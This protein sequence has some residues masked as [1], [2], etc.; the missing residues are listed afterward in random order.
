MAS[1]LPL[2]A[3]R[4]FAPLA[5]TLFAGAFNDN[6]YRTAMVL[7]VIYGIYADPAAEA[8]FSALAGGLFI[9]PFFL[10]SGLAGELADARDKAAI[11]RRV[12]DAE[13]VIMALGALGLVLGSVPLLL[14]MLFATGLQST[15]FGPIKYAL[16]PQH[17]APDEV[18][19]GTG[20]VEAATYVA[21]LVGIVA[22]GLVIVADAAGALEASW[23]AV[24]VVATAALGRVAA[25]YIPPAPPAAV[26]AR[27]DPNIARSTVRLVRAF[28]FRPRIGLAIWCISLFWAMGTMLAAIF[29]PLV[30]N[31]LGADPKV[32]TLFLASFSVGV[33]VG[34]VA[35]NRLLKGAVSARFAPWAVLGMAA[36]VLDL[37][38]SVGGFAGAETGAMDIATFVATP[39]GAW[40]LGDLFFIAALAGM[41]VV[42]L[43]AYL[44]THVGAD[45]T[46]RAVAANNVINSALMV[47]ASLALTAAYGAGVAVADGLL[48]VV[49]LALV[50]A[51]AG[52]RLH[53]LAE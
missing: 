26:A 33:A 24:G 2:L 23:G 31:A 43:Y 29:P 19:G 17:L 25:H 6:L 21:I 11:V 38:R 37:Y 12:K 52:W 13:I 1:P 49:A 8:A 35:I 32:A 10:F 4:R 45:E 47:A 3:R 48:L 30:K 36:F 14:A 39:R 27:I 5:L 46:A 20:L 51:F 50:A 53:R 44:T 22:G 16:L 28:L 18:L 40:I 42:P 34:S 41:Y 9:L 7:L 15:L